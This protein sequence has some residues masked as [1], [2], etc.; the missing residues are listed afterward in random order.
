[1]VVK[2]V[3]DGVLQA[4]ASEKLIDDGDMLVNDCEM[5]IN[6][7]Q[8]S[9]WSYTHFNLIDKHFAIIKGTLCKILIFYGEVNGSTVSQKSYFSC[10]WTLLLVEISIFPSMFRRFIMRRA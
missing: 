7:G 4:N 6:D 3:N 1:M 5:L 8:M 9:I 2:W 10:N